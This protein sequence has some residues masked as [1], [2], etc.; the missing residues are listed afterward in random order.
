MASLT[1]LFASPVGLGASYYSYKWADMMAADA[2]IH[3]RA[4]GILS[5]GSR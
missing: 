5:G 1:H 4:K 3:F 2:F